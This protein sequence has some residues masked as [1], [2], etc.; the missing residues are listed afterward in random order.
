M[1]ET[2]LQDA[3]K[4]YCLNRPEALVLDEHVEG[5]LGHGISLQDQ[6]LV[7]DVGAN[8]GIF[9]ARLRQRYKKLRVLAFEPIPSIFA[10]LQANAKRF[11]AEEGLYVCYNCGLSDSSGQLE[12]T[13]YPKAP[14][15]STAHPEDWGHNKGEFAE[16]VK[17]SL[18]TAPMWYARLVPS[19][20]SSFLAKRL[21]SG[22]QQVSCPLRRL[23]DILEEE[24][25]QK[26]DLLKIDCEGAELKVLQ[27]IEDAHWPR[28]EQVVIEV[29][30]VDNRLAVIKEL[31]K[32]QG[33]AH[34]VCEQEA[35]FEQTSL[36]NLFA[37][38]EA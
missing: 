21:R 11:G 32:K 26:V 30:N 13:Y 31:L 2:K 1:I 24:N 20:L 23:S 8:I 9:G 25:I 3:T 17:G 29:H 16:A 37:R 38:R 4:V 15:L 18:R 28:I 5:Y 34:I 19:F 27:G 7:I 36:S 33:F 22:A 35:G 12:F 10:V 6:S 14:A